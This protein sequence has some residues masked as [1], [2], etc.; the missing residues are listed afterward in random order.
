MQP[1]WLAVIVALF[2]LVFPFGVTGYLLR[3]LTLVFMWVILAGS[4]NMV[5]G[6]T[7]YLDFGHIVFFGV[8][9]YVTGVLMVNFALP[10]FVS[11][12]AGCLVALAVGLGVGVPTMRLRGAYFAI[13]MLAFAEAVKQIVFEARSV[14]GGGLG[15]SLPVYANYHFFYY[16]M[17]LAMIATVAVTYWIERSEFGYA[18]KAIRGSEVAAEVSG[19][20]TLKYK[21]AAFGLSAFFA[22][23]AG[24]I[25][26]YWMTFI[27]P[28]DVFNV[29]MTV[30]M[31]VMMFLGG[32][33]T[34][35][36]PIIGTITLTTISEI[37][38]ARFIYLYMIILGIVVILIVLVMPHGVVGL[39]KG[40][41]GLKWLSSKPEK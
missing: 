21:L 2:L 26:A 37:L 8:G 32:S 4:I 39:L 18:L 13:A 28:Y 17:C 1:K 36:G 25:Y 14:T 24:G 27:Y 9:A 5:T 6:Y 38:W 16:V 7:G 20:N 35:A 41:R 19:V 22:G 29:A 15:L 23:M 11:M 34:L 31:I 10:F 30:E 3:F 12:F 33:G 40:V